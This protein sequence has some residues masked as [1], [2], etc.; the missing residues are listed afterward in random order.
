MHWHYYGCTKRIRMSLKG[1]FIYNSI[2]TVSGYLF[3]IIV[4]PY[5]SRTLGLSNVGIV[6]F[7]DNLINYFVLISMMGITTVGVR[8]IAAARVTPEK[9]SPTFMSLFSLTAIATLVAM[10]ILLVA[11]YTVPMLIPY[12]DLLWVGQTKLLFNLFLIE[13]FFTGMENFK[14]IT[15]R[16]LLIRCLYVACVFLFVRDASDYKLYY[17][18]LVAMVVVNATVN[19]FYSRKFVNYSFKGVTLRPFYRAFL[20]MGIYVLLTNVYTMLNPVWLGFATDTDQVGYFTTATKLHNIIM[21]VLLSFTNILFPR[22]S[23]LLAEGK[24]SEFWEKINIAFDAILLFAFPT[25]VYMMVAGPDLLHLVVGDGF[26]GSYMPFRIIMPL[27]LIIG[28]EQILVIQILM[29]R[30]QDRTVLLNS[31]IGAVVAMLFNF[32]LTA[33]MG[34][35]GSAVVWI[36]AECTIMFLS[37]WAIYRKFNY[38]PPFKRLFAYCLSYAPLMMVLILFYNY[39]ENNYA[40]ICLLGIVTVFYSLVNETFIMKNKVALQFKDLLCRK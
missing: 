7:V 8:E 4:Y 24:V 18:I 13:W 29:A 12:R 31:F 38:L 10:T 39:L 30:H 14:Y 33:R 36:I 27:V 16:S 15:N 37:I 34:A 23:N 2:L 17:V 5:I 11:M 20:I 22:V 40:I 25:V 28:I 26:E 32:I 3:P 9:L 1:N 21:A 35:N 19:F 6:N